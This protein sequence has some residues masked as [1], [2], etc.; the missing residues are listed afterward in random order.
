[1]CLGIYLICGIFRRLE[2]KKARELFN[3]SSKW[4]RFGSILRDS[5]S[6]LDCELVNSSDFSLNGSIF[7]ILRNPSDD[8]IP[9][10]RLL[11]LHL[12]HNVENFE[13]IAIWKEFVN[14]SF[15]YLIDLSQ[16]QSFV[17]HSLPSDL[18]LCNSISDMIPLIF[19]TYT[20]ESSLYEN[21]NHFLRC[22]P[23]YLIHKFMNELQGIL[24]YIYLLQSSIE[25]VQNINPFLKDVIVYRGFK[26]GGGK[27]I[28]LYHSMVGE[29]IV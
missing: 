12:C 29:V 20:S 18:L 27:L 25:Y 23:I 6:N 9:L 15:E 5:L 17:F 11:N 1:M 19:G 14:L 22:F 26:A 21:V 7:S 4:N 2:F 8:S 28:P 24:H 13:N 16:S 3:E 10:I